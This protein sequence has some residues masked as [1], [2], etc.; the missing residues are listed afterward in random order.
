MLVISEEHCN[1]INDK[2]NEILVE[3]N[4][5]PKN[6][7]WNKFNSKNKVNALEEFLKYLFRL[8]FDNL[9]FIHVIIWDIHDSRHEIVGRD[10]NENLSRM[11]YKLIKNFAKDKLKNGDILTI[12][13]DRNNSID[14]DLIEEILPNDGIVNTE[15]LSFS[16]VEFSKVSI[17]ESN[18]GENT[19]IQIAD[20]F[21]G[22]ARTSYD[23]YEK[24][25]QWLNRHQLSLFPNE[26]LNKLEISGRERHRFMIYEFVDKHCKHRSWSV[27]LKEKKGFYTFNKSKPLN[28]WF[29]HPQHDGDKAPLKNKN[30]KD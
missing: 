7:K 23:D 12:F 6:F 21:A 15:E 20:I 17:N 13:P 18:T 2:L 4:L 30:Y 16:T 3:Y 24:Y 1:E 10:D 29:Y 28:F 26:N 27:S 9:V 11:Y 8:M 5:N 19:L 14:W 25:E 22:M